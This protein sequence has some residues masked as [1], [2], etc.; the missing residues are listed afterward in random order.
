M[1]LLRVEK[2]GAHMAVKNNRFKDKINS[3]SHSRG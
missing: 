1:P 3:D 2:E